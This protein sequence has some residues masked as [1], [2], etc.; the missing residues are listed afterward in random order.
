MEKTI[1]QRIKTMKV[2]K[3]EHNLS[4]SQILNIVADN[5]GYVSEKTVQK[6]FKEGNENS[7]FHYHTISDLFEA[8]TAV[9][10]EDIETEDAAALRHIISE[11]NKQIDALIIQIEDLQEEFDNRLVFYKNRKEQFE[12]TI[13]ILETQV[14]HLK[15][16][17]SDRKK[18]IARKDEI[19][20]RLIFA[21]L[22]SNADN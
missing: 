10:G 1:R 8:L 14:E 11:R 22:P 13:N 2:I 18:S 9:Y 21:Y 16:Q 6:V 5:G 15:Q 17:L 20:E 4:L 12:K 19:L 7:K 3:A